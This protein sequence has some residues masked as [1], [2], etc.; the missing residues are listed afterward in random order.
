MAERIA[1]ILLDYEPG[2]RL[3]RASELARRYSTSIDDVREVYGYLISRQMV[4]QSPD[5][6]LYR[7]SPPEYLIALD[8]IPGLGATVDP[9][10]GSL[11]CMSY[12]V[13]RRPAT[14]D[15]GEALRVT[16]GEPVGV[17]RITWALVTADDGP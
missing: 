11:T 14:E 10:G 6:R 15:A 3:P 4:R 7:A 16:R 1:T 13:S 5:G 12:R 9:M 8:G 17:L 2:A